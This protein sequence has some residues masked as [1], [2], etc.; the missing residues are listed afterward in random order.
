MTVSSL[1]SYTALV[2]DQCR[3][4]CEVDSKI[5]VDEGA[6][7]GRREEMW[8]KDFTNSNNVSQ[9]LMM[10]EFSGEFAYL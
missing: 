6:I 1:E 3:M 10:S 2:S 5:S 4:P 9:D 8:M 7:V